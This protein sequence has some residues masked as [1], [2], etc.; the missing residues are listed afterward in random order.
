MDKDFTVPADWYRSF[1]TAPVN[2]FWER[3][4]PEPATAADV[5]FLRRH[6]PPPPAHLLDMPCGAGR[7]SL[8]LA[9]AGYRVTGLDISADAIARATAT[10]AGEGL[11]AEF[12][13][14]DMRGLK[15]QAA[16]D[17]AF[18]LGNSLA[19]FPSLEMAAFIAT[20]AGAVCPGGRLV[21]DTYCC[22]ESLFPL[23]E[24]RDVAFDGGSYRSLY[25][26]D[27]ARSVLKTKAQLTLGGEEH[28]LLYAHHIV[29]SGELVRMVE[30]AGVRVDAL[31]GDTGEGPFAPGS[32]RLLL[33]GT[34]A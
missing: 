14:R 1:F 16:F 10:A 27:A 34:R 3:M 24:E 22:A 33:V 5:A 23:A 9:R 2:N 32:P 31:F 15:A 21:L 20:L 7:H 17:G 4:V 26:Y 6:L 30:G 28:D 12:R 8:A 19:Y 13:Q 29:T 18:C 25:C 11:T